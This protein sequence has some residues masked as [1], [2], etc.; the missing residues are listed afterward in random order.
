MATAARWTICACA[1]LGLAAG[2][3]QKGPPLPPLHL[4]PAAVTGVSVRRVEDQVRLRFVLPAKNANGPGPVDLERVDIFAITMPAGAGPPAN[5][6]LMS[7]EHLVGQVAVRP[8][9]AEGEE[10]KEGDT[11]PEPGATVTYDE[12]LTP[13]AL[14][15]VEVEVPPVPA[16]PGAS[17]SAA[18][19]QPPAAPAYPVRVYVIR[20]VTRSGRPGA[21]SARVSLPV[22]AL[23]PPP[24]DVT[25]QVTETAVVLGWVPPAGADAPLV[26]NVYAPDDRLQPVNAAP[27]SAPPFEY[28]GVKFGTEVCLS[29]RS[30]RVSENIGIEGPLSAPACITP[31]DVFPPAAPQGL[32]VVPTPGQIS[33]IWN[34]NTETDLAG[35]IVLRGEAGGEL[36]PI[37]PAP[38]RETSY[39]DTAVTPGV[40]Y[41]YA[42]AAVDSATPPNTSAPSARVEETA[43]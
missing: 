27:L 35:Y 33:L 32:A 41:V 15:P 19:A 40:R 11:R 22:V 25:A 9:P 3:G 13:A 26:F 6:L 36:A 28:A 7:R 2:C 34:A 10:P 30:A 23:P 1:A 14:T 18:A 8:A 38:I 12:T 43:R 39:R 24:S 31:R 42:I 4:V 29:V 21:P 16:A 5:R 20:G 37:T 17:G